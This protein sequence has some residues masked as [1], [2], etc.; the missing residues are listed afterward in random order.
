[1]RLF[2]LRLLPW[3]YGVRNLLRRP[4]RTALT[5]IALTTVVLLVFA[6]VSFIRGLEQSLV[7]SGHPQV[8]LAYS[9]NAEENIEN[10]SIPAT[11]PGLLTASLK[12]VARQYGE[13]CISPELYLGSKMNIG[14]ASGM[15]LIRG[16]TLQAPYVRPQVRIVEGSWP[17]MGEVMIGT[18]AA[19]KLGVSSEELK[20]G[21]SITIEAKPWRI[22]GRFVAGGTALESELWCRLEDLQQALKR[23]DIS[24]AAVMLTPGTPAG[25]VDLFCKSRTDLELQAI[26]EVAYYASLQQHYGPVRSLAWLVVLLIANSGVFAGMN[27]ESILLSMSASLL[28]S[29]LAMVLFNGTTIRFTMGAFALRLDGTALLIG[30]SAGLLL[31]VCGAIPPALK[32]LRAPVAQSLKAI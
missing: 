15:G 1:M 31:G 8:V 4:V 20:V 25:E 21:D 22:S 7:A 18:L 29:V 9:I 6:V 2:R 32:A 19:A 5:L 27:M 26:G 23:Q 28:A 10:S 16:V 17:Q 3:E 24:L 11:I 14:E 12:G 30:T 13:P